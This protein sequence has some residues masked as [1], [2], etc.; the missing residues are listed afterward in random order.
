MFDSFQFKGIALTPGDRLSLV[1]KSVPVPCFQASVVSGDD[2]RIEVISTQLAIFR[3]SGTFT[4]DDVEMVVVDYP[5][6][7]AIPLESRRDDLYL[8][9]AVKVDGQ[10]D[11]VFTVRAAFDGW[12]VAS[13][14]DDVERL[15]TGG[16]S[17]FQAA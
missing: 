8:G 17:F 9:Q 14:G 16:S 3:H 5:G 4:A 12:V 2:T 13:F 15:V 7:E 1:A 10:G 6:A 11:D